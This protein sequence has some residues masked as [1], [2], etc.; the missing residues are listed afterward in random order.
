[1]AA[2]I[3]EVRAEEQQVQVPELI[4]DDQYR[5]VVIAAMACSN[6]VADAHMWRTNVGHYLSRDRQYSADELSYGQMALHGY[7][8]KIENSRDRFINTY[9]DWWYINRSKLSLEQRQRFLDCAGEALGNGVAAW[10][11]FGSAE[12]PQ[13]RPAPEKDKGDAWDDKHIMGTITNGLM[14]AVR[15]LRLRRRRPS[16]ESPEQNADQITAALASVQET[17]DNAE[18]EIVVFDAIPAQVDSAADANQLAGAS[19][20]VSEAHSAGSLGDLGQPV[21]ALDLEA[22]S[23]GNLDNHGLVVALEELLGPRLTAEE[24]AARDLMPGRLMRFFAGPEPYRSQREKKYVKLGAACIGTFIAGLWIAAGAVEARG[25]IIGLSHHFAMLGTH[26]DVHSIPV[27]GGNANVTAPLSHN[28]IEQL[29]TDPPRQPHL[30]MRDIKPGESVYSA[31]K[32]AGMRAQ[33]I[34][35]NLKDAIV[36]SGL[37]YHEHGTGANEWFSVDGDSTTKGILS[38]VGNFLSWKKR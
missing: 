3:E 36:K 16:D 25:Y 30:R 1:M 37:P 2:V 29:P 18:A 9:S 5:E 7:D 4:L 11:Y 6:E 35:V 31:L 26:P 17:I 24:V 12:L 19:T 28:L 27:S 20:A 14:K 22:A 34:M 32:Y 33:D 23:R 21:L 38:K 13:Q 15:T 8:E 10:A